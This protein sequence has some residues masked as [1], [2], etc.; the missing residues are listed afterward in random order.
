[1][2]LEYDGRRS[3]IFVTRGF[4]KKRSPWHF[5]SR[6][7]SIALR[8][9]FRWMMAACKWA[10]ILDTPCS[11]DLKVKTLKWLEQVAIDDWIRFGH[12]SSIIPNG[13]YIT[14][15]LLYFPVPLKV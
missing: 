4:N 7:R 8:V 15:V 12:Y 13:Y 10:V 6:A 5:I 2:L 9:D 11:P 14:P 1:M 3:D